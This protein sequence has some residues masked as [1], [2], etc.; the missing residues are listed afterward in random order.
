[1][2][3]A[4]FI[5]IFVFLFNRIAS[6]VHS[7]SPLKRLHGSEYIDCD[8]QTESSVVKMVRFSPE[9]G[10][11]LQAITQ[12]KSPVKINKYNISTKTCLIPTTVAFE[13][14]S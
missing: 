7:V 3:C 8:I 12:Q 14:N 2:Y 9:K 1:M 13:Y 4:K 11:T 10:K 5:N 6:F